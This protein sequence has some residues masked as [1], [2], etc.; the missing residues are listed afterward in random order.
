[1][2]ARLRSG[3]A[4]R[5]EIPTSRKNGETWGTPHVGHPALFAFSKQNSFT[6]FNG[7]SITKEKTCKDNLWI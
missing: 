1:M 6:S 4:T 2:Q 5:V 7:K 3:A